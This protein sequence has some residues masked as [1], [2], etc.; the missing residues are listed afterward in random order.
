MREDSVLALQRTLM[1][2]ALM[3]DPA[4]LERDPGGFAA[5]RGL[6]RG[7][8][9]AF[10]RFKHR[11]LVYRT[12]VR[13]DLME[14]VETICY[15]T[16]ALM[17]QAGLWEECQAT[18]LASRGVQSAFYRDLSATFLGWLAATGWGQERWPFLLQLV[19]FEVLTALVARHPGGAL[20]AGLRPAPRLGDRLVLAAPTQVVTY[21]HLVHLSSVA[22]PV[23]APGTVHLLAYRDAE[24]YPQWMELTPA[25]AALLLGAQAA[26][27]G[28]AA[29]DLGLADLSEA[30]ELLAR[31]QA[32]GAIAGFTPDLPLPGS[33]APSAA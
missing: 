17:E 18:F 4:P 5:E 33:P 10:A 2:A 27:I 31:F 20:P 14:P 13:S 23:P 22:A 6:P 7:D 21:Q 24:G 19:H 11:L 32:N 12:M 8:Q 28:Q 16:Q 1:D 3:L 30:L 29:M 25:T 9:Q 15:L 26:S